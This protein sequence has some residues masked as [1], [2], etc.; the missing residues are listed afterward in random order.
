M[1]PCVVV[2]VRGGHGIPI[3]IVI[4][5]VTANGFSLVSLESRWSPK[6]QPADLFLLH[7]R[8]N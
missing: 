3:E 6:S 5:E 1:T 7:F 4:G 8:K 2:A